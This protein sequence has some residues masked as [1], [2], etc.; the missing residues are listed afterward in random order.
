MK[1]QHILVTGSA[2]FIA[3]NLCEHLLCEDLVHSKNVELI[4]MDWDKSRK[5]F[6]IPC[7]KSKNFSMIWDDINH[8]EDHMIRLRDVDTIYHLAAAADIRSSL[9]DT[10]QDL[11]NNTIGTHSILE[12]MR[13]K[14]IKNLVFSSTSSIYGIAQITPTP[15]DMPDIRPISQYGASKL[16]CEA[17][18]HSYCS[19]YGMRARIYRFANVLGKNMHRG[20]IWDFIHKL[21]SNP[22]E[23]EILGDG[24]QTKSLFDVSDCIRGL[25]ELS[26]SD[27]DRPVEIY[28]LGNTATTTVRR[29]ADTV[30]ADLG[31]HPTY[32]F[33][34]GDRGWNGDTPYT[35]L[36]IAKA[37]KAGW[38]P[39]YDNYDCIHRTVFDICQRENISYII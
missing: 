37:Q 19:L 16:A 25:V 26:R 2:G 14:D 20:V 4:G 28:N 29:I 8:I 11:K 31:M 32:K 36:S 38:S 21:Q 18:I 13:K 34:G 9:K 23:L 6:L 22:N 24:R 3:S 35:I 15:E 7:F 5:A 30:C 33:S 1:E 17:F 10:N 12:F 39:T 27:G